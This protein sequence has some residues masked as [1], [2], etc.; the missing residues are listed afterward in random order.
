MPCLRL[1]AKASRVTTKNSELVK[2]KQRLK[3]S[4]L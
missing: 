2:R 4:K 3:A 1:L